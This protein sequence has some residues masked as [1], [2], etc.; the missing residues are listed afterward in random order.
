MGWPKTTEVGP[1]LSGAVALES[2]LSDADARALDARRMSAAEAVATLLARIPGSPGIAELRAEIDAEWA[3]AAAIPDAVDALVSELQ[4]VNAPPLAVTS[5]ALSAWGAVDSADRHSDDPALLRT[6]LLRAWLRQVRLFAA[7]AWR[8][9]GTEPPADDAPIGAALAVSLW[10][11][12]EESAGSAIDHLIRLYLR[13]DLLPAVF[14]GLVV[15]SCK[16]DPAAA[17]V[18]LLSA[19][20]SVAGA[21]TE[22][23]DLETTVASLDV[24]SELIV[25]LVALGRGAG[26]LIRC[27]DYLRDNRLF[28][29]Y[30]NYVGPGPRPVPAPLPDAG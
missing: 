25:P 9:C 4:S 30:A 21:P 23:G 10:G 16:P 7:L 5:A 13:L 22:F 12:G 18:A 1:G 14:S 2:G 3:A 6:A 17:F 29:P 24:P 8:T 11:A 26:L 28:R 27:V 19:C 15:A 20:E